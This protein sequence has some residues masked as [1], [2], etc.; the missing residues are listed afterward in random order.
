MEELVDTITQDVKNCLRKEHSSHSL[1]SISDEQFSF[2]K[3]NNINETYWNITEAKQIKNILD[4]IIFN[5]DFYEKNPWISSN[6]CNEKD[7]YVRYFR[8][9]NFNYRLPSSIIISI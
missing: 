6:E 8:M 4:K 9:F 5:V 3:E 1:F 2:W 7:E